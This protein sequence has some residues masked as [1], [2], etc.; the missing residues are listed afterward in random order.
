LFGFV[1]SFW[2]VELLISLSPPDSPRFNEVNLDYRVLAFTLA[3]SV[4]TGV[5]FGLAPALQASKLDVNGSLKEGGQ[6]N[7][8]YRRTSAR[9]LLLIG[10]V[11]MSLILLVGAGLL[12]KSFIRLQ[13]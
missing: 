13:E 8:S 4:F 9:S 6:S 12:I 7:Q 2:L 11:A 3:I 10:E 5:A 1:L